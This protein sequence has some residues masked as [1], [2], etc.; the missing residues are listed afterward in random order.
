MV[1]IT[2][3]MITDLP[4]TVTHPVDIPTTLLHVDPR[5]E[6]ARGYTQGQKFKQNRVKLK[7]WDKKR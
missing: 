4:T 6:A 5:S 2:I 1:A 3:A 7:Q